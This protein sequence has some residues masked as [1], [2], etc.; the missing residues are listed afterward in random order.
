MP[1]HA[2]VFEGE[3]SAARAAALAYVRE[4][5][6]LPLERNPDVVV[7]E[8]ERL[9]IDD[10][11]E[12]KLRASQAPLSAGQA[13][14]LVFDTATREAQNALLKLLEEPAEATY[15]VLVVPSI[16]LLLPTVRSR[17]AYGGRARGA[18]VELPLAERFLSATIG[19]RLT[20][21]EPLVKEK[22]RARV[23][24]FLDAL[25]QMLYRQGV[26][27]RAAELREVVFVRGYADDRSASV[28]MLLE[29]LVHVL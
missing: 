20:L 17:L 21:I 3:S 15:F 18:P 5:L 12:L 28:K 14:V 22:D 1:H 19:E 7:Y 4:T 27:K 25:E 29:H 26:G 8:H 23:R 24:A 11:R 2:V 16:E 6:L 10:A 9:G 13:F